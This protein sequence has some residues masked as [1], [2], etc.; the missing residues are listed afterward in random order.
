MQ[1][2]GVAVDGSGNV[3]IADQN[4]NAIKEW[5]AAT[6]QVTTLVSSGLD[7]PS[8]VA[9]DGSGNVYIADTGNNAIKE[10]SAS[11]QQVT[12][13]VSSGLNQPTAVAVDG[14]GNV[15]IADHRQQR[16]QGVERRD[17]AGDHAGVVGAELRLMAWRW[18]APATSTS[19]IPTTTRSRSG[20]PSTQQ[21]TTLV[22]SGLS[23]P[24]G[25]AVDGSGNVYIAD[26]GNNAIKEIPYAFVGPASLTEPASAGSDSLLPVLPS[27]TS[28]TGVFAPTSDQ[29]W[30][31]IGTIANG[32]VNFSFTANTSGCLPR[33]AHH[34]PGPADPVTQSSGATPPAGSCDLTGD[35]VADVGDVRRMINEA[36][37]A[38]SAA[39][40]LNGGR[41]R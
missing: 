1:P 26:T 28:L 38:A 12:T 40:D 14:S 24:S 3:Y 9:V 19:R 11:T 10:W 4:N 31:T 33:G 13:L 39:N 22:S 41:G 25:V 18:T 34:D 7:A 30:L 29:S 36:L 16:D 15:Y 23:D 35:N 5:S 32:V 21:V 17:A 37:G 6:Q 20:A 27:T 8:G 2:N